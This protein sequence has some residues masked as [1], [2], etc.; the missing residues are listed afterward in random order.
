MRDLRELL[1]LLL[2]PVLL[3]G[4]GLRIDARAQQPAMPTGDGDQTVDRVV[5]VVGDTAILLSEVREEAFNRQQQGQQIPQDPAAQDSFYRAAMQSL[6]D[7]RLLLEAAEE[8]GVTVSDQQVD[9]LFQDRF[10]SIQSRFPSQEA[11]RQEVEQTGQNMFQFRQTIRSQARRDLIIQ[12]LRQQLRQEDELPPAEVSEEEIR[13]YF[14][15]RAAGRQRPG[16]VSFDRVM[17]APEPDSAALDSTRQVAA[18]ALEAIRGGTEFAVAARRYSD[19]DGSRAEGGD[20]GWV[21]RSDLAPAFARAAWSAPLGQ[22]VGPVRS[23]FGW[24]VL[25]IDNV[26]GGERR[27]R[28]ILVRHPIDEP[29]VESARRRA[30]AL[31]DSLREGAGADRLAREHGL[32]DEQVRFQELRL[33]EM[34]GRLGDPYVQALTEPPPEEG[35]VRGPFRVEGSYGLPTFVIARVESYTPTGTYRLEDVRDRIRDNLMQQKQFQKYVERLRDRMHVQV[36]L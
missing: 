20:L 18:E 36:L 8:R 16:S 35:E 30:E 27:V 5:A 6:I 34:Q 25:R 10:G 3:A 31:A 33:D 15:Q 24:H 4:D 17:V 19:D 29:A 13:R 23:R 2:L 32:S 1:P 28:H 14:E 12:R 22:A 9:Q 11:F 26:R 7:Q 21:R